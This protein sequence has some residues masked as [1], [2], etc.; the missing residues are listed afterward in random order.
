MTWTWI[1]IACIG[2]VFLA[3]T[4]IL[5]KYILS[6]TEIAKPSVYAFYSTIIMWGALIILFFSP[7]RWSFFDILSGLLSGSAFGLGLYTLYRAVKGG[8]ASHVNPISGAVV[9]LATYAF[10]HVFLSETLTNLQ[11]TGIVFLVTSSLFLSY[12][13]NE[14]QKGF[15]VGYLWAVLSGVFFAASHVSAKYLY[16]IH[17]FLPAFAW[18]R[19]GA[20]IL[21]ILLLMVPAVRQDLYVRLSRKKIQKHSHSQ[22]SLILVWVAKIIGIVAV[23]MIQYAAALGSVTMVQAMSGLQYALMFV[24]IFIFSRWFPHTF[25]E[26]FSKRELI[27]QIIGIILV[28]G[29]S[30]FMVIPCLCV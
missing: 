15:H 20:G 26:Y 9:M 22:N 10:S 7:E 23:V 6:R 1:I 13:D 25:K 17:E 24:V 27:L 28:L 30:I 19:A 2:Y 3:V 4:F 16:G 21:G 14:K 8:E 11:L 29:G 5:D 12:E 18:T